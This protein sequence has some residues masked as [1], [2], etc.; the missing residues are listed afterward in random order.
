MKLLMWSYRGAT[1]PPFLKYTKS[2]VRSFDPEICCFIEVR[3]D[4]LS[5]ARIQRSIGPRWDH[6]V[7]LVEERSDGIVVIWRKGVE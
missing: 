7:I 2:L 4:V 1:K 5:F 3:L 6:Y